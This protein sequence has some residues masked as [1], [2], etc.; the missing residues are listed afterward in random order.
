MRLYD[1]RLHLH[2]LQLVLHK[3]AEGQMMRETEEDGGGGGGGER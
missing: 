3:E 1:Q 2:D